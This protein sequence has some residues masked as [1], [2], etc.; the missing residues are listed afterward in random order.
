M[1]YLEPITEREEKYFL[2]NSE[3]DDAIDKGNKIWVNWV[4]VSPSLKTRYPIHI[5][6]YIIIQRELLAKVFKELDTTTSQY[7]DGN[8]VG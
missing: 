3:L 2:T 8:G 6:Q 4:S 5:V 1:N 7:E